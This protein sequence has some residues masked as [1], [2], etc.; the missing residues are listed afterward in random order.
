M[1]PEVRL[2]HLTTVAIQHVY[3]GKIEKEVTVTAAEF[4]HI[5]GITRYEAIGMPYDM[6]IF[7]K[8]GRSAE[9]KLREMLAYRT[10][11]DQ[12]LLQCIEFP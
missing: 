4:A 8:T 12:F 7:D 11:E 2:R 3:G 9:G 5:A 10:G 1:K 6:K